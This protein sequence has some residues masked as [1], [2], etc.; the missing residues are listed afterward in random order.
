[1]SHDSDPNSDPNNLSNFETLKNRMNLELESIS[2]NQ[3][4]NL[5]NQAVDKNLISAHGYRSGQYEILRNGEFILMTPAEAIQYLQN[6]LQE[7]E[8]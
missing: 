6:L 2:T 3:L 8:A 5:A 1:M 4:Y 7:T